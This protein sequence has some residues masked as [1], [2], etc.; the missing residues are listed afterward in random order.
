MRLPLSPLHPQE[1]LAA[2]APAFERANSSDQPQRRCS[3]CAA[4]SD[5]GLGPFMPVQIQ[6]G[7]LEWVHRDCALWAPEVSVDSTG[8][9][10]GAF[11][12]V[13]GGKEC[14]CGRPP[15]GGEARSRRA[16]ALSRAASGWATPPL[17]FRGKAHCLGR[18]S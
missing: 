9:L 16:L 10:V 13:K 12:W 2:A 15:A 14:G 6:N 18:H 11:A 1:P 7:H 5:A 4:A 3:L 17:P 8:R